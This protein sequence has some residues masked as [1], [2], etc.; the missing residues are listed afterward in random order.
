M[1]ATSVA[2]LVDPPVPATGEPSRKIEYSRAMELFK[3]LLKQENEAK[4]VAIGLQ[5]G[6]VKAPRDD[7]ALKAASAGITLVSCPAFYAG[8]V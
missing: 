2:S 3:Q 6:D 7:D 5:G 8:V 1:A 4:K